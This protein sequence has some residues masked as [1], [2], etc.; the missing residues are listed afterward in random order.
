MLNKR[1]KFV[2][3]KKE[4]WLEILTEIYGKIVLR[5]FIA[6][7]HQMAIRASMFRLWPN[8]STWSFCQTCGFILVATK[9]LSFIYIFF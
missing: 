4:L 3:E 1:R 5:A 8:N 9:S 7:H 6:A 2:L